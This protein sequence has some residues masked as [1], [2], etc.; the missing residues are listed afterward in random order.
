MNLISKVLLAALLFAQGA[1]AVFGVPAQAMAAPR[2][3][4]AMYAVS[5][6]LRSNGNGAVIK[7]VQ[8]V[9]VANSTNEAI[10]TFTRVTQEKYPGYSLMDTVATALPTPAAENPRCIQSI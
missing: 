6:I 8:G 3:T 4:M 10:G 7:L 9:H 5:G 1:I 2:T